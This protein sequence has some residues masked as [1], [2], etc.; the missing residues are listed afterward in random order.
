V[1]SYLDVLPCVGNCGNSA[2]H[3]ASV[4]LGEYSSED[5][6][7]DII[8][9]C[10]AEETLHWLLPPI[11]DEPSRRVEIREVFFVREPSVLAPRCAR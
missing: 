10:D 8:F 2:I 4:L 5:R 3:L 6:L 11:A 1:C 9:G 7:D